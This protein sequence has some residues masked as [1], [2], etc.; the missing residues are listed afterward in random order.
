MTFDVSRRSF[1]KGSAVAAGAAAFGLAGCAPTGTEAA[2]TAEPAASTAAASGETELIAQAYVNP[3]DYDYRANT[4]DFATLLSP[5]SIGGHEFGNRMAKSAAGSATYLAGYTDEMYEYYMNFARGG[6]ELIGMEGEAFAMPAEGEVP[7]E[8]VDFFKRL[9][10]DAAEYNSHFFF[11]WA[12]FGLP[13]DEESMP[14]E[15]IKGIETAGVAL[16]KQIKD[17]G[18]IG[19]EINAAG[20]NQGEQFLSRFHNTRTDEYGADSIENRARFVVECI[21]QIKEACGSD[22]FV[23]VLIDCVEEY[24]DIANGATL[25]TLD[26][27]F[28]AKRTKVT[29]VDEGIALAKEFEKAG[30]DSMHL[31]LGPLGNHPCQFASDLYF[32]VNGV[33]GATGYG[34]QFNFGRHFGGELVGNHSGAGMLFNIA[35]RYKEEL[36][37][38]CGVVTYMDPAHAPDYF[39]QALADGCA[40]YYLMTRPLTVDPEYV[41]KIKDGRLD[42]IAPCT[43]CLHCHAGSN[44]MN[45]AMSYCRVNALTQRVMTENGPA[46]YEL[47]PAAEPKSVMIVGGG[48]A[49]M[50]AARIAALR[51]HSVS[52]YEKSGQLG[53]LLAFASLVKGPHENLDDLRAYL[54]RQCELAGVD[55]VTGTEVTAETISE[56]NP[57]VLILA[58]GGLRDELQVD[59]ADVFAIEDYMEA[60]GDNIVVYGSNEQAI[61]VAMWLTVHKKNVTI[62]TPST[63]DEVDMQQSQHAKRFMTTTFAALGVRI[64]PEASIESVADGV[65]KVY[66]ADFDATVSVAC[67]S[68]VNAADMLPNK[69]LLDGFAGESYSIGDCEAPFNIALAIRGGNDVGRAI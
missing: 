48:P 60:T 57:D 34:T 43:R 66:S 47:E 12:P 25:M 42:E 33:E 49:G 46:T 16:A 32:I 6:V 50:E 41:N 35:K 51:G 15:M 24:D 3:Q 7:A 44:E 8:A 61:D 1:L 10:T 65:M 27:D 28:T 39:E 2:S 17:M 29:S 36:S 59:G 63:N 40:D 20:F 19:I 62:V 53:G 22:F 23:Q 52:L 18:F 30:A 45:R 37:I 26:S 38:P 56:T 69:G 54:E 5:F 13:V 21:Q 67:D 68:V 11:Q 64:I 9:T 55:V 4:T 58:C 14:V 31:R